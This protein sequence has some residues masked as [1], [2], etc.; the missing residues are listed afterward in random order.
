MKQPWPL[1][2]P[3][4]VTIPGARPHGHP[5]GLGPL[6]GAGLRAPVDLRWVHGAS[7]DTNVPLPPPF[8]TRPVLGLTWLVPTS[9]GRGRGSESVGGDPDHGGTGCAP[10]RWPDAKGAVPTLALMARVTGTRGSDRTD[11]PQ[12]QLP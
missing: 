5:W 12:G 2:P 9:Q 3:C 10:G 4:V 1:G 8:S 6:R 7:R 11:P